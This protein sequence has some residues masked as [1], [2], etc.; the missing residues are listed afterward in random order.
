MNT[1]LIGIVAAGALFA[2][3]A[4]ADTQTWNDSGPSSNWS[5]NEAN[6]AGGAVWT[7]GNSAVFT[8]GGGLGKAVDVAPCGHRWHL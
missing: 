1:R 8:G 3:M 4:Q 7:N 6:W 2:S 5:T